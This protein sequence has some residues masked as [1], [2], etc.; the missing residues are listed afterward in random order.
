MIGA[1]LLGAAYPAA[2]ASHTASHT[3]PHAT[4]VRAALP[5]GKINHIL[6]IEMENEGYDVTFGPTSPAHYLNTTLRKD[7]RQE[8]LSKG[9]EAMAWISA[10]P[11]KILTGGPER[12]SRS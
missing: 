12:R 7:D 4:V 8:R 1:L 10:A 2:A 9:V 11:A 6:L 3:P 5:P